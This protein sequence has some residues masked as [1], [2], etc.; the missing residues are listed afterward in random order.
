LIGEK[1][2]RNEKGFLLIVAIHLLAIILFIGTAALVITRIDLKITSNHKTR[3]TAFWIAEAAT[4]YARTAYAS[5]TLDGGVIFTW[6]SSGLL[7]PSSTGLVTITPD[8]VDPDLG[9]ISSTASYRGSTTT[10]EIGFKRNQPTFAGV[11]GGVTANGP[12]EVNGTL[13]IDGRDH[14]LNCNLTGA[15]GVI[16]IYTND[17]F[18]QGGNADVGGH[19]SGTDYEL[20]NPGDPAVITEGGTDATSTPDA[21]IGMDEGTLKWLAQSGIAGGQYV[22]DP[23]NLTLPLQGVTYVELGPGEIWQSSNML[24]D[25]TGV[26]VVHNATTDAVLENTNGGRF[27]GLVIADDIVHLHNEI[28]GAL[29]T[30]TPTPSNGN[31]LGNG[32]GSVCFSSVAFGG[33]GILDEIAE[34]SWKEDM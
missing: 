9:I 31:V 3:T 8:A 26:L 15:P 6:D 1:M 23:N 7:Y 14:D 5:S 18:G 34:T 13:D 28:V 24:T 29:V 19:A 33:I 11:L 16:G 20:S 22:T 17:T 30:L 10:V 4:Q 2:I 25:G 12:I 32:T 27:T 21:A